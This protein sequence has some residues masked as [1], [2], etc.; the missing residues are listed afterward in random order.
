MIAR[1]ERILLGPDV[2]NAMDEDMMYF[3]RLPE[4]TVSFI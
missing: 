2:A 4:K 1:H 3:K